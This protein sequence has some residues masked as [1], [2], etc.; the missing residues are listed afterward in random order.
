[1]NELLKRYVIA[2]EHP[3]ASGFE[4]LDMLMV[5]DK[6]ARQGTSFTPADQERL[7]AADRLLVARASAFYAELSR[8][9]SLQ[10]ERE[11]RKLSPMHWWWY[12]DVLAHLPQRQSE[13]ASVS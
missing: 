3:G 12:L 6:L 2:V 8:I 9:T 5:R 10:Y 13:L 1:M 7:V 4:H 11:Q